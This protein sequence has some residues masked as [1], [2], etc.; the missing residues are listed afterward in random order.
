MKQNRKRVP[1]RSRNAW[2][3]GKGEERHSCFLHSLEYDMGIQC[4]LIQFNKIM[5]KSGEGSWKQ[6]LPPTL[7]H[8]NL[9]QFLPI[10]QKGFQS[11][12]LYIPLLLPGALLSPLPTSLL[13]RAPFHPSCTSDSM[14]HLG[15]LLHLCSAKVEPVAPTALSYHSIGCCSLDLVLH[16]SRDRPDCASV[17]WI[18]CCV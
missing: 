9:S 10:P 4:L 16:G 17:P 5:Y 12:H 11:L 2:P 13:H 1:I 7:V 14:L 6:N 15:L 8:H 3:G 18:L